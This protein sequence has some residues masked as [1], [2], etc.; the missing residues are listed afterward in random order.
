MTKEQMGELIIASKESLYRVAKS[1][2]KNDADCE[3]AVSE[4]IVICFARRETLREDRY[5]KTWMT[6]ILIHECYHILKKRK[7]ETAFDETVSQEQPVS[8]RYSDLYQYMM[9]LDFTNRITLELFYIEGYS[10]KE[11]ARITDVPEGTVK[12]RL[13]RGREKLRKMYEKEAGFNEKSGLA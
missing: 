7:R 12:G 5:A 2:L 11:I 6:R 13:S 3:D 8:D 9:Q 10:I 1:I 4:M